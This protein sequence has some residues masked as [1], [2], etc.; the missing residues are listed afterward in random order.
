M[1][2][3]Y[4]EGG[5]ASGPASGYMATL[6]GT[7]LVVSPRNPVSVRMSG[8]ADGYNDPELKALVKEL[9]AVTKQ[10]QNINMTVEDGKSFPAYIKA[11]AD[12]V[13]VSANERKGVNRRRLF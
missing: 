7:E 2:H 11:Y 1:A 9:I 6:H 13:R 8:K 3:K 4:S 5:I 10:K 12:E